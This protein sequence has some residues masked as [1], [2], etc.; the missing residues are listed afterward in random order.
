MAEQLN[1]GE[2]FGTDDFNR[3]LAYA[4][5]KVENKKDWV[6]LRGRDASLTF[7]PAD[8]NNGSLTGKTLPAA[9]SGSY[10][11]S[12]DK[13]VIL[14]DQSGNEFP[15]AQ[16]PMAA[17]QSYYNMLGYYFIDFYNGMIYFTGQANIN[18]TVVIN[19]KIDAPAITT[20]QNWIFPDKFKY[21]LS[22]GIVSLYKRGIDYDF[23]NALQASNADDTEY[24]DMWRDLVM[25][26]AKLEA[27]MLRGLD[28]YAPSFG[29][30]R[31]VGGTINTN[32]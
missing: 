23:T 24:A 26:N 5:K 7:T 25:W 30:D 17:R 14:V 28:R 22:F 12:V 10:E 19:Y 1:A 31:F 9:V 8:Y 2:T 11:F 21:I 3:L 27:D 15:L 4:Q 20:S 16:I 18:Y 32:K 6:V 13:P 29:D